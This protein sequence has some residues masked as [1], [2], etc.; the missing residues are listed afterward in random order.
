VTFDGQTL[1]TYKS[2]KAG[3]TFDAKAFKEAHPEL[4]AQFT[5]TKPGYR[6]LKVTK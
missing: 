4:A 1:Y 3:E 5:K 6:L 2:T